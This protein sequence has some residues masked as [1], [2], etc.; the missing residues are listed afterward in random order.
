MLF[1]RLFLSLQGSSMKYLHTMIRVLNL[2]KSLDFYTGRLGLK[3]IRR[4]EVE[5]GRFT[6]VFLG[7][8]ADAN[9]NEPQIELTHNWDNNEAYSIGRNFGHLAFEVDNIYTLCEQLQSEGVTILR[10]P[11]DGY[12]AFVRCPDNISIE[13]LQKGERLPPQEP[14]KSMKNTGEW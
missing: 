11:K 5:A 1:S 10:P 4:R 6:L 14:W 9:A 13:L 3:V 2:E 7:L 8:D 12:M